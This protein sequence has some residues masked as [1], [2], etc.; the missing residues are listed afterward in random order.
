VDREVAA[1][2]ADVEA[3]LA[4]VVAVVALLAALVALVAAS[5]ALVV[6][7]VALDAAFVADVDALLSDVAAF[8][9]DV[10]ASLAFVVAVVALD[11]A[12]VALDA[13]FVADVDASLAFV[14]AVVSLDAAFVADVDASLAFVVAV[15][16]LDAALVADVAASLAFVVAVVALDAAAVALEA[17]AVALAAAA[18]V[19]VVTVAASTMRSHF[20]LSVLVVS[21]CAPED[22]CAVFAWKMLAVLVSFTKSRATYAVLA[23]QLPRNV[24]NSCVV[25]GAPV[26]LSN[27]RILPA[28]SVA[29]WRTAALVSSIGSFN[30]R[31]TSSFRRSIC[32]TR[33]SC[34]GSKVSAGDTVPPRG[35]SVVCVKS[36]LSCT[37]S[38]VPL[39]GVKSLGLVE[40]VTV[41]ADPVPA[42]VSVYS[43]PRVNSVSTPVAVTTL[44]TVTSSF[45][46]N[47]KTVEKLVVLPFPAYVTLLDSADTVKLQPSS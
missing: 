3:S 5:L 18:A 31:S 10:D 19:E 43:V 15:V 14:L 23:A 13:A 39:A 33:L 8:D 46:A 44:V 11:A 42:P 38:F 25:I 26:V 34:I 2:A 16:A 27:D 41:P 24:P 28:R 35:R 22:V 4:F 37:T 7:V 6:A 32:R 17:A 36:G 12:L 1:L 47:V 40:I 29:F 20:A 9:A 30:D 21:G 45:A